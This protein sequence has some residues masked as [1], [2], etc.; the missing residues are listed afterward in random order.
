MVWRR[1]PRSWASS[2]STARSFCRSRSFAVGVSAIDAGS[3][4]AE[5]SK[6]LCAGTHQPPR[7]PRAYICSASKHCKRFNND[8]ALS[9]SWLILCSAVA[10]CPEA[11]S[12]CSTSHREPV[13]ARR[14]GRIL[15]S[16][17]STPSAGT[18]GSW[19]LAKGASPTGVDGDVV[20]ALTEPRRVASTSCHRASSEAHVSLAARRS[21]T[22]ASR[23]WTRAP[24]ATMSSLAHGAAGG[25]DAASG[26]CASM[27]SRWL[28][29]SSWRARLVSQSLPL[30]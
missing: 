11:C 9:S 7:S 23:R 5:A 2:A 6:A 17:A 18:L 20:M 16:S 14:N 29:S 4:P 22:M 13:P 10:R 8:S 25:A 15:S 28:R 24:R 19:A 30:A 27:P 3:A 12:P 1:A 26:C 21:S